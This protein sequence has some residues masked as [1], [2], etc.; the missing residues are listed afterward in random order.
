MEPPRT[1]LA[2]ERVDRDAD[3]PQLDSS[4]L[5]RACRWLAPEAPLLATRLFLR[6]G[7]WSSDDSQFFQSFKT[8]AQVREA[9]D[10][11]ENLDQL[12]P[13][14]MR[15]DQIHAH[16]LL[17]RWRELDAADFAASP[18]A[19]VEGQS[20][21]ERIEERTEEW[22]QS[23]EVGRVASANHLLATSAPESRRTQLIQLT[24][25]WTETAPEAAARWIGSLPADDRTAA[26]RVHTGIRASSDLQ[27]TIDWIG[28]V[29]DENQASCLA[30]AF[31]AWQA[32]DEP[33]RPDQSGWSEPLRQGWAD[34]E[35]LVLEPTE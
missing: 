23:G 14:R 12:S 31:D 3:S 27:S 4:A 25:A 32:Q 10:A 33:A 15:G 5:S 22:N 29:T 34:L 11:F 19:A 6:R 24:R 35:S 13:F 18:W 26:L 28:G 8:V 2:S 30:V 16:G 20:V 21:S 1:T 9:L 7:G 17:D